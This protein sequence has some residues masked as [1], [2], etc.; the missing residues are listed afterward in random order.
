MFDSEDIL[1][2]MREEAEQTIS[3]GEFECQAE[4]CS[5][6]SFDVNLYVADG[7]RFQGAAICHE[8]N[9]RNEV[10]IPVEGMDD[11]ESSFDD[12]EDTLNDF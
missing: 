5:S 10:N 2:A 3:E 4:D 1:E 8:C 12:L 11:L 9:N 6:E 7:S